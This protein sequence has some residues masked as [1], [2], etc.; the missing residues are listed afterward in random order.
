MSPR[1]RELWERMLPAQLFFWSHVYNVAVKAA[2]NLSGRKVGPC[3]KPQLPLTAEEVAVEVRKNTG[4]KGA[5]VCI[6]CI[7]DDL[8]KESDA[9]D[10]A[11]QCLG[12]GGRLTGM[13]V[14]TKTSHKEHKTSVREIL[15]KEITIHHTLN[16]VYK[17][18]LDMTRAFQRMVDAVVDGRNPL[19]KMITHK[20]KLEELPQA[21]DLTTKKLDKCI[22]IVVYPN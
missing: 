10:M 11:I 8:S 20:V 9:F 5:S 4:D 1:E 2:T 7:S 12:Q 18:D 13:N 15:R 14:E 3:R 19:G 6:M 17:D 22:K 21:L 16:P